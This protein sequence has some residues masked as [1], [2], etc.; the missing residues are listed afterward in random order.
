MNTLWEKSENFTLNQSP[1]L[2]GWY[3]HNVWSPIIYPAFRNLDID[4]IR[5]EG[6]SMASSDRKNGDMDCE[7]DRKKIG[8]KGDGIFRLNGDRL[9]FV[10]IEA[11]KKWEGKS[12]RNITDNLKL[13]K[14]LRDMFVQ[15][16]KG[17][18]D[19]EQIVRK[20]LTVGMLHSGNQFQLLMLDVP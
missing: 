12:G 11:G 3:Q 5:G 14:M 19:D 8:R 1:R 15:L 9:E 18:N 13:S 16:A 4:L 6:S 10:T 20:L 17:C 2:E 7:E